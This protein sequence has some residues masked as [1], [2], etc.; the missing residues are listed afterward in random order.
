MS[1]YD[2]KKK[3]DSSTIPS[4]KMYLLFLLG[5]FTDRNRAD[6]PTLSYPNLSPPTI[7][8]PTLLYT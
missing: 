6:F 4:H 5:L 8:I 3:N 2:L 7:E 1:K